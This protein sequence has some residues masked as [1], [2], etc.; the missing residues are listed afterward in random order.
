M[1][2]SANSLQ[3]FAVFLLAII[4]AGAFILSF[5]ALR[6]MFE[7][8]GGTVATSWIFPIIIDGP[9]LAATVSVF[10][11]SSFDD[12]RSEKIYS[13]FVLGLFS[14]ASIVLNARHVSLNSNRQLDLT[15]STVMA[16]APPVALMFTIHL[17]AI[18]IHRQKRRSGSTVKATNKDGE[19]IVGTKKKT[20]GQLLALVRNKVAKGGTVTA[21]DMSKW[22]GASS[23]QAASY[24]LGRLRREHPAAFEAKTAEVKELVGADA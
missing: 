11:L 22:M 4:G 14:L 23:I 12:K 6:E 19:V 15:T 9:I 8:A 16:A 2:T 20:D 17:L 24:Q 18:L 21:S 13:W 5:R 10:Y 1:K 3:V 7:G